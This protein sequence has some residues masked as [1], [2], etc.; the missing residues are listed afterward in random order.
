L[1]L[2][3]SS[4][5]FFEGNDMPTDIWSFGSS[6]IWVFATFALIYVM[7]LYMRLVKK[8]VKQVKSLLEMVVWYQEWY[9]ATQDREH[10]S[11][12]SRVLDFVVMMDHFH[13]EQEQE[14]KEE[15]LT[16]E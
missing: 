14:D 5:A 16:Q 10:I 12:E 4:G 15:D 11:P 2:V 3:A 9:K 13:G 1:H 8:L 6:L 7:I